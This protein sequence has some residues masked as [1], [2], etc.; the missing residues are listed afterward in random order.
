MGSR[1]TGWREQNNIKVKCRILAC[2]YGGC[3]E[4]V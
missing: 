1:G 4:A 2:E 3:K